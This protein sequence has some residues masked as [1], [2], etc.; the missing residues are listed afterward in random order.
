MSLCNA[1][2]NLESS[3]TK[4]ITNGPFVFNLYVGDGGKFMCAGCGGG[5][6][7]GGE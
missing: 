3:A 4:I 6:G 2:D 1:L 7:G 5:G